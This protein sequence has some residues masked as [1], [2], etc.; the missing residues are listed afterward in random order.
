MSGMVLVV[1]CIGIFFMLPRESVSPQA[2]RSQCKNNLRQLGLALRTYHEQFGTFPPAYTV[3]LDGRRW[4]SWRA[5]LLSALKE[6]HCLVQDIAYRLDEPWDGP[7]NRRFWDQCPEI[8]QCPS[9]PEDHADN[10]RTV[11]VSPSAS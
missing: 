3:G 10:E 9:S 4:H 8:F 2:R 1:L 5:L 7:N 6:S 11:F